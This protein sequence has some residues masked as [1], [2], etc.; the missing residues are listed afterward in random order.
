MP[1]V[2]YSIL[3]YNRRDSVLELVHQLQQTRIPGSEI[4]IVD[5]G[6]TDGSQEELPKVANSFTKVVLNHNNTG[7][8]AGWNKLVQ[9]SIG[10]LIFILNDDYL[11]YKPGWEQLYLNIMDHT[12]GIMCFPR[13]KSPEGSEVYTNYVMEGDHKY[14]HNFRLFGIPREIYNK[15]GGFDEGFFY[16]YEDTDFNMKALTLGYPLLEVNMDSVYLVH[17][18]DQPGFQTSTKYEVLKEE[19]HSE[20]FAK[21]NELFY[22]KWPKG[23]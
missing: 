9:S 21:N 3:T 7:V 5:N 17:K 4:V 13:S 11:I 14:T 15:V 23:C 16:G 2:S 1:T 20:K 8:S 18:R 22:R 10:D 12:V 6:S 19:I